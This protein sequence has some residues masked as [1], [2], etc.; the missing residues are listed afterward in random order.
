MNIKDMV[1]NN[2]KV[3]FSRYRKGNLYYKT[4]CG[5]EFPVPISDTGDGEFLSEDKALT[6]MRW[7][8]KHIKESNQSMQT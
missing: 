5:F 3:T 8:R 7:I 4:E 2:K 1:K 6:Y